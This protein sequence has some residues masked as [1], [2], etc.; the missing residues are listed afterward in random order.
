M[1]EDAVLSLCFVSLLS[2]CSYSH[3]WWVKQQHRSGTTNTSASPIRC[4]H[5]L[6]LSAL[7]SHCRNS[8]TSQPKE[9]IFT[10]SLLR[11]FTPSGFYLLIFLSFTSLMSATVVLNIHLSPVLA[12]MSFLALICVL[13]QVFQVKSIYWIMDYALLCFPSLP[14]ERII[15]SPFFTA[16]LLLDSTSTLGTHDLCPPTLTLPHPGKQHVLTKSW[17]GAFG[18]CSLSGR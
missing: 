17:A 8:L 2:V 6:S 11:V 1:A 4:L 15:W 10:L 3:P 18:N 12:L 16:W 5:P 14:A 13:F 7:I 9:I